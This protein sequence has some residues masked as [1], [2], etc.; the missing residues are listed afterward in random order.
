MTSEKSIEQALVRYVNRL[1]GIAYK[2][3]APSRRGVPDR[4][5][6][7]PGGRVIFVE[8]K[9]PGGRLSPLQEI[10]ITRLRSLGAQVAIIRSTQDIAE[11]LT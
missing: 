4:L 8:V 3:T 7:L 6:V 1:G 5:V 11:V 9:A 10:E 2:F